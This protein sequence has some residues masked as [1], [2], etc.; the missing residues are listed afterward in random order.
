METAFYTLVIVVTGLM[1]GNEL[2]VGVFVHPQIGKLDDATHVRS[3]QVLARVYGAIMPFWYA[4]GLLLIG[5]TAFH[6]RN[7]Q[8]ASAFTLAASAAALWAGVIVYTVVNLAPINAE[9]A[10]WNLDALPGNWQERRRLWDK[11][12][13]GRVFVLIVA[14]A[15]LTFACLA[16]RHS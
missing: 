11:R 12:H 3:A 8:P 15:L 10:R 5:I 6:L 14:F 7:R 4:L 13:L 2:A 9:V 1:V 16:A